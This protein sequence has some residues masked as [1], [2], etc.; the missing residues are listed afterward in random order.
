MNRD[1]VSSAGRGAHLQH[2]W[3][4]SRR[5]LISPGVAQML[6]VGRATAGHLSPY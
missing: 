6:V 3:P 2:A 4:N 1:L 5:P